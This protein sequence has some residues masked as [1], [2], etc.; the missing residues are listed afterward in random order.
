MKLRK[1]IAAL[2]SVCA[3]AALV[4]CS[5]SVPQIAAT[6]NGIEIP[7]GVYITEQV[8]AMNEASNL[9]E[10]DSSD[11]LKTTV[12][13]TPIE[14]WV[15]NR[16]QELVKTYV[17][18]L[19]EA[20]RLG[21]ALDEATVSAVEGSIA[22]SWQTEGANFERLGISQS[23]FRNVALN[24]QLSYL[25]FNAYYGEGGEQEVSE[26][27]LKTF[28]ADNY[29]RSVMLVINYIDTATGEP[30]SEEELAEQK[31]LFEGYKARAEAGESVFALLEEENRRIY[32]ENKA[33]DS[34]EV[35]GE[36]TPLVEE[37]QEMLVSQTSTNLPAGLQEMLFASKNPGTEFYE[38]D[39]YGVIFERRDTLGDGTAFTNAKVS[40]LNL[41]KNEEFRAAILAVGEAQ[42]VSFNNDVISKF[43]VAKLLEQ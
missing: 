43:K 42:N 37:Q 31:A 28:F 5:Q 10:G 9:A 4:G 23:S 7:A 34:A 16:A 18:V 12:D 35:S 11:I 33:N 22:N 19:T 29:R 6:Y 1:T 25:V 15:N 40:L 38:D 14:Q 3:A 20:E 41:Y 27:E 21:V 8:N 17:G 32:D 13:G 2:L 24:S 36:Y 30:L 39:E 26:D